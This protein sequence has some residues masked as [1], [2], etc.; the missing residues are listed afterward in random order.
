MMMLVYF[1]Q[2][3]SKIDQSAHNSNMNTSSVAAEPPQQTSTPCP[4]LTLRL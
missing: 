1:G 4:D 3:V 2:E